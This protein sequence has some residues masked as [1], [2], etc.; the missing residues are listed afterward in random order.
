MPR[1]MLR[2]LPL[3]ARLVLSLFLVSVGVGYF[4]ALVQLH[5]QHGSRDGE[6]LPSPADVVE[7]FAGL[8]KVDPNAPA[9]VSKLERLVNGP[10]EGATW[11]G[12]GSMAA[13][14]HHKDGADYKD[15]AKD[16]E[17]KPKLIA[18]RQGEQAAVTAWIRLPEADRRKAYEADAVPFPAGTPLTADY[19]SADKA[20]AKVKTIL[21]DR[22]ARCHQKGAEQESYPLEA[23]EQFGKYLAV[24]SLVTLPGGWG[25]VGPP[26]EH[27]EADAKYP[28]PSAQLQHVVRPHR[29]TVRVHPLPGVGAGD[30]RPGGAAGPTV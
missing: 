17:D 27:R 9:P 1:L 5:L 8:K 28:R 14:F 16:P 30:G 29:P 19:L 12:S 18:E 25:Q 24:P 4:S 15:R 7:V 21:T 6:P 10:L 20:T 3:P 23:Y 2:D 26:G 22:C 13:A 11:N